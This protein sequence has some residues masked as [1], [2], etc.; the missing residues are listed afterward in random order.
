MQLQSSDANE[1]A[2]K[3]PR[4]FAGYKEVSIDTAMHTLD[5]RIETDKKVYA[6]GD[7]VLMTITTTDY[8]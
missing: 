6:P 8:Q 4:F 3:E 1:S 5:I 7:E 2:R